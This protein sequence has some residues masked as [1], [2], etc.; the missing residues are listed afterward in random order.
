MIRS[1]FG[2]PDV[3]KLEQTRN[4]EG[5]IRAL[6]YEK[7][8]VIQVSAARVLAKFKDTRCVP[9]LIK[10][11]KSENI[12]VRMASVKALGD[13]GDPR[14]LPHVE[15]MAQNTEDME[16]EAAQEALDKLQG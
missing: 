6:E 16:Q 5:L 12:S 9:W 10:M 1:L 7:S 15:F 4:I 11:L 2:P 14:A 13:I 3:D 8:S